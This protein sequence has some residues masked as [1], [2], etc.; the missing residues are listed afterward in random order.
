MFWVKKKLAER[1]EFNLKIWEEMTRGQPQYEN[2]AE[3]LM[4]WSGRRL[5][6]VGLLNCVRHNSSSK[7]STADPLILDVVLAKLKQQQEDVER[8]EEIIEKEKTPK[9]M[10]SARGAVRMLELLDRPKKMK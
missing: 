2:E 1:T 9:M 5:T 6:M 4:N 8:N 10:Q 3:W 7:L